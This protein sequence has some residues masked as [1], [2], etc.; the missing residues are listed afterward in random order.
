VNLDQPVPHLIIVLHL[1]QNKMG[2][3]ETR[4]LWAACPSCHPAISVKALKGTQSTDSNQW[5]GLILSSFTTGLLM[6]GVLLPLRQLCDIS[7]FYVC[8]TRTKL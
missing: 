4:L 1:F 3:S 5:S 2:I 8:Q 7:N 6:E